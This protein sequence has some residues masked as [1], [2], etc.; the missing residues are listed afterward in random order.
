M[1]LT[2]SGFEK[3]VTQFELSTNAKK[4]KKNVKAEGKKSTLNRVFST[5][6]FCYMMIKFVTNI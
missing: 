6:S 5:T 2:K 1:Q 4:K 3:T